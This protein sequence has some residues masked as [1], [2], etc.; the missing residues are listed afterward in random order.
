MTREILIG[1]LK[2][3]SAIIDSLDF[4]PSGEIDAEMFLFP[5][6]DAIALCR[7]QLEA[8]EEAGIE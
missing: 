2:E 4:G 5:A 8:N 6:Y 3:A 7:G 1:K